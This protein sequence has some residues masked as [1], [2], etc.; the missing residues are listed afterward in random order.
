M[1][2]A[3]KN[4]GL[5]EYLPCWLTQKWVTMFF[6]SIWIAWQIAAHV[7]IFLRFQEKPCEPMTNDLLPELRTSKWWF[8]IFISVE[9][10]FELPQWK[11]SIQNNA[12]IHRR[13]NWNIFAFAALWSAST[14][15]TNFEI[16]LK[17]I[18]SL[19][20]YCEWIL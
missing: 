5:I 15:L 20:W 11:K 4:I 18:N 9:M 3:M 17:M 8:N 14:Y 6:C 19:L 10:L 13:F 2:V 1:F 16:N 7:I 12:Q